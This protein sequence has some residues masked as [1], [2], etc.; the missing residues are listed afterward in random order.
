MSIS[1]GGGNKKKRKLSVSK[2]NTTAVVVSDSEEEGGGGS[3]PSRAKTM[4][5]WAK[6]SPLVDEKD[7]VKQTIVKLKEWEFKLINLRSGVD[8]FQFECRERPSEQ[9]TRGIEAEE[10]SLMKLVREFEAKIV[11]KATE[12]EE[13]IKAIQE[14]ANQEV[15][16]KV[17]KNRE[18]IGRKIVKALKEKDKKDLIWVRISPV[19]ENLYTLY[20]YR[21]GTAHADTDSLN[22]SISV[23]FSKTKKDP[24]FTVKTNAP[25]HTKKTHVDDHITGQPLPKMTVFRHPLCKSFK[26]ETFHG[27]HENFVYTLLP[28]VTTRYNYIMK[29]LDRSLCADVIT[30]IRQFCHGGNGQDIPFLVESTD[31]ETDWD[32]KCQKENDHCWDEEIHRQFIHS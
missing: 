19:T 2:K 18:R 21:L 28:T 11:S 29:W 16:S 5:E 22:G 3:E 17:D 23:T 32:K 12:V 24:S 25:N 15:Y 8:A 10:K 7:D 27:L 14:H 6:I 1:G 20:S 30:I 9:T 4:E 31:G 26:C 13:M